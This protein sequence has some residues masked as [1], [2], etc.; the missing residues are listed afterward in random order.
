MSRPKISLT[1]VALWILL[2]I[3][4]QENLGTLQAD[5]GAS[6]SHLSWTVDSHSVGSFSC[7]TG[8]VE[9]GPLFR[10]ANCDGGSF[11]LDA[12]PQTRSL[13]AVRSQAASNSLVLVCRKASAAPD[14]LH[15]D[16]QAA[17][18]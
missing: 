13:G 16:R 15:G 14:G 9:T 4:Y 8:N 3:Y 10:A 1:V 12:P 6:C 17:C 18:P 5:L 11:S 2:S 7:C